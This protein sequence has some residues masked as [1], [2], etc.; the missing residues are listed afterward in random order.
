MNKIFFAVL[1][2]TTFL[3]YSSES[4]LPLM[5]PRSESSRLEIS[6]SRDKVR[7]RQLSN[8][9]A[10]VKQQSMETEQFV[11]EENAKNFIARKRSG[12][13]EQK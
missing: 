6:P 8:P 7:S 3:L 1:C 5:S 12:S 4:S 9:I 10:R 2:T 11:N 13:L